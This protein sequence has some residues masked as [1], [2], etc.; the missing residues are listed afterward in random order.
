MVLIK[1]LFSRHPAMAE[2]PTDH[3]WYFAKL[4]ITNV[5]VLDWFGGANDVALTDYYNAVL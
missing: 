1:A 2:W 5:I 3:G 4:D